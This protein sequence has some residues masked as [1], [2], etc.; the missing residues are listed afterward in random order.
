MLVRKAVFR[1]LSSYNGFVIGPYSFVRHNSFCSFQTVKL[2]LNY[3][4]N[5]QIFY[6]WLCELKTQSMGLKMFTRHGVFY[7]DVGYSHYCLFKIPESLRVRCKKK[8]FYLSF[9]NIKN[10][11]FLYFLGRVKK[12]SIYK[13]KGLIM[14]NRVKYMRLRT[15]KKQTI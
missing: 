13:S 11:H 3:Y 5:K 12:F 14:A 15:G 10:H 2:W 1:D 7:I 4:K 6:N 8:R 9:F